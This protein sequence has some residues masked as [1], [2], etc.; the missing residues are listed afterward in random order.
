MIPESE[1]ILN[2][3]GS[4][5]H[6]GLLPSQ[7]PS[8]IITVG[9]PTRVIG[10][11]KHFDKILAKIERREF[12]SHLGEYN[13]QK[14]L[15]ISTG[16][17]T[18]NIDI[19]LNELD[20]LVNIDFNT[21]TVKKQL[22]KLSIVRLG[23]T[24]T[25]STNCPLDTLIYSK[26]VVGLDG[27]GVHYQQPDTKLSKLIKS[28]FPSFESS[29]YGLEMSNEFQAVLSQSVFQASTTITTAG[30]YAPQGRSIRLK[31]SRLSP[32]ELKP[33][34]NSNE[35]ANIEMETAGIY[36]LSHQLGHR[37]LSLSAVLA[38]RD[39]GDFSSDPQAAV[40]KLIVEGLNL[41]SRI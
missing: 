15:C 31:P 18:D 25:M 10:V 27:I 26:E 40:D 32:Q 28:H 2:A 16:I 36:L 35:Y 20:A 41:V 5:Y 23:T 1:F 17:G 12:V 21:R 9:D 3:D 22:T 13:G 11:S 19:V 29:I 34:L 30:F 39:T 37:A 33:F 24:G 6:L 14:V 7:V 4:I 38:N 8:K